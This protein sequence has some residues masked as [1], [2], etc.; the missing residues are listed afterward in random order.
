MSRS[1]WA[2]IGYISGA[3]LAIISAI[4]VSSPDMGAAFFA[5]WWA[6]VEANGGLAM[7]LPPTWL[8]VVFGVIAVAM[9][10]FDHK[11]EGGE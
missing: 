2:V 6:V 10:F 1:M 11:Q 8:L 7:F 9:A 3:L 5:D 4:I